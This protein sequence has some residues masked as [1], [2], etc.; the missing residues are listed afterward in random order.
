LTKVGQQQQIRV[1]DAYEGGSLVI[2]ALVNGPQSVRWSGIGGGIFF[3]SDLNAVGGSVS[4]NE[5]FFIR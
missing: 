3:N 5:M 1:Y 2:D 4:L